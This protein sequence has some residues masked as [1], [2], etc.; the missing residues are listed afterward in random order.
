MTAL[1]GLGTHRVKIIETGRKQGPALTRLAA[2]QVADGDFLALLDD[3]D[4][5]LPIKTASH[6]SGVA[7][8][9]C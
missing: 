2:A 8:Y 1:R 6:S 7:F 5:W 4:A 9:H 3:D